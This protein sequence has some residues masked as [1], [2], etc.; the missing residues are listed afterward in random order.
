MELRDHRSSHGSPPVNTGAAAA[1]NRIAT[2]LLL[3]SPVRKVCEA[4]EDRICW[5]TKEK[6][7]DVFITTYSRPEHK[8]HLGTTLVTAR[9]KWRKLCKTN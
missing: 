7:S 8:H 4:V 6:F 3:H 9:K 5:Q 1:H 2:Q